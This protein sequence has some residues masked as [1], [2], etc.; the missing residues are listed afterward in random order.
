MTER[1]D[2]ERLAAWRAF[3]RAHVVVIDALGRELE[4]ARGLPL[5]W[6][7]VLVNLHAAG[8]RQRMHEL[9]RSVLL[10]KSGITRLVDRMEDAGLLTRETCPEDRRGMLAALTPAGRAALRAASPVHLRGLQ[11]HFG[12]HLTDDEA[13]VLRS[14][15][16]KLVAANAGGARFPVL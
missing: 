7:D 8:G 2:E 4:A 5:T 12:R 15:L 9:A 14:A 11:E 1:I 16:E 6:Y 13:A 10:S 3:L